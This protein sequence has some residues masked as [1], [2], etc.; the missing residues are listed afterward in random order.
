[1]AFFVLHVRLLFDA[2]LPETLYSTEYSGSAG[3]ALSVGHKTGHSFAC[4]Y[5]QV[6]F[7][8]TNI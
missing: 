3:F 4:I 1:M 8:A 5:K 7:Y 6:K 2:R